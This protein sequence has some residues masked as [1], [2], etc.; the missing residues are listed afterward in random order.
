MPN[1]ADLGEVIVAC[2]VD[3]RPF[4]G[5]WVNASLGMRIR[6]PFH[7]MHGPANKH[8]IVRVAGDELLRDVTAPGVWP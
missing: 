8:G 7:T 1:V 5:G 6:N 4:E 2:L 3:R